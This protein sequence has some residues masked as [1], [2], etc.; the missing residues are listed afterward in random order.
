MPRSQ[1]APSQL[2]TNT[3][4]LLQ[5]ITVCV[6]AAVACWL[7]KFSVLR[8]NAAQ[9]N[10][11]A[12]R[13]SFRSMLVTQSS[14]PLD[15]LTK[16][17]QHY[18]PKCLP[19]DPVLMLLH[20]P[21]LPSCP[22]NL[23]HRSALLCLP[24]TTTLSLLPLLSPPLLFSSPVLSSLCLSFSSKRFFKEQIFVCLITQ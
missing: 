7:I 24:C 3:R 17:L 12:E 14:F 2:C 9:A 6:V 8:L 1:S 13:R 11:P 18:S 15:S 10:S 23:S 16:R 5:T 22:Q 4:I 19:K 21:Y 20:S